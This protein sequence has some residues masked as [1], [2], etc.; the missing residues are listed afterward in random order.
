MGVFENL[1]HVKSSIAAPQHKWKHV[2]TIILCLGSAAYGF[3][4]EISG[5]TLSAIADQT[6]SQIADVSYGITLRS[7]MFAV[8]SLSSGILYDHINRQVGYATFLLLLVAG[9]I[10]IPFAH[11]LSL[12]LASE[13]LT[14][15]VG[16][17]V[18][19]A[20]TAWILEMWGQAANPFLQSNDL[21][22]SMAMIV[23]PIIVSPFLVSSPAVESSNGQAMMHT[24]ISDK[25]NLL[26]PY[27]IT[28]MIGFTA[29]LVTLFLYFKHPFA[30]RKSGEESSLLESASSSSSSQSCDSI[31]HEDSSCGIIIDES[32]SRE[33][34]SE[35][36]RKIVIVISLMTMMF[37]SGIESIYLSYLT[38][39]LQQLKMEISA[40]K[41]AIMLAAFSASFS[42][43]RFLIMLIGSQIPNHYILYG[44]AALMAIGQLLLFQYADSSEILIWAAVVIT[45]FGMGTTAGTIYAAVEERMRTSNTV[46]GLLT[47]ANGVASTLSLYVIGTMVESSPQIFVNVSMISLL[48]FFASLVGQHFNDLALRKRGKIKTMT[49]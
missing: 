40:S 21:F 8:G 12:Y 15:F 49:K 20:L 46:T 28:S 30:Q 25:S 1:H 37:Y 13:A 2:Y 16:S 41:S 35:K 11:H 9:T 26:I 7:I 45:G 23:V 27:M 31:P 22:Y 3:M 43:S 24:P 39:Y 18:E 32:R 4:Y 44:N 42:T 48:M 29:F 47:C 38:T 36:Q 5:S 19:V 17:A 10:I 14:G 34:L 33:V 6:S